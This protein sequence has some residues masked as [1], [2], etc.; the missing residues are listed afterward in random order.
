MELAR[1]CSEI[2]SDVS[3]GD[4]LRPYICMS[5]FKWVY[6]YYMDFFRYLQY[7]MCPSKADI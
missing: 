5:L 6:I 3:G 7:S 1:K 2:I 4:C